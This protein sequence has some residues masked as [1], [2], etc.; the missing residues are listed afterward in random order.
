MKKI[1]VLTGAGV[2][3]E[4][5][6]KTFRDH[7]GLWH[8]HRIEDVA[9]PEAW[10][11]DMDLVNQFY[12]ERRKNLL[13]AR[14]N[15]AHIALARL[16][17]KYNVTVITQNVDDLHERGGSSNVL[18]LHGELKKVRSTVDPELVYELN[19]WELKRGDLCEKGSQ[20]RPHIV[21]FGE[22]VPLIEDAAGIVQEADI[23]IIIG[24]SL[25]VYPAAGL[26]HYAFAGAPKYYI[27]PKAV[28]VPFIPL[29][30]I[31]RKP[32]GEGVPEL[33]DK[34]MLN[35]EF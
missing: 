4:S 33:V 23:V 20:L 16:E 28:H 1:A 25:Q 14:P 8:D 34:L 24:T 6:L 13:E 22:A 27:D 11:R 5:G 2:S 3:A 29:L 18:H 9:T 19:G 21:W 31:I 15:E 35:V 30:E 26:I 7:D 10:E 12:N 32:A 17:E